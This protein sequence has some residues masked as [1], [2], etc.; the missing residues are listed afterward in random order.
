VS[1]ESQYISSIICNICEKNVTIVNRQDKGSKSRW[2]CEK[3]S[4]KYPTWNN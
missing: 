4:Y 1:L 2:V 3:C